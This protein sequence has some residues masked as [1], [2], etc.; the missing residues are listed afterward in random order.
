VSWLASMSEPVRSAPVRSAP[1][2]IE[3]ESF[4]P[5]KALG[6]TVTAGAV[7]ALGEQ[8]HT[9]GC[10]TLVGTSNEGEK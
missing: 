1:S 8:T 7:T 4:L 10:G 9:H 3:P 6:W 5:R 2:Q